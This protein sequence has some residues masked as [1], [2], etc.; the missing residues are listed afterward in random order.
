MMWRCVADFSIFALRFL[1]LTLQST[2]VYFTN[3]KYTISFMKKI[4]LLA[5]IVASMAFATQAETIL[6]ESFNYAVGALYG[7]GKWVKYGAKTSAPIQVTDTALTFADYQNAAAGK[8]VA[9][10]KEQGESLQALFRDKGTSAVDGA[11]YYSALINLTS[12]PSGSRTTAF[13]ALTGANDDDL[14]KY[15]DGVAGSE[16][17]G[18]FAQASGD[19]FK[20]GVSRSVLVSG[21]TKSNVCWSEKELA[22]GTT[23][24]VVVKYVAT[25]GDANGAISLWIDPAKSETEPTADVAASETVSGT[26]ADVRGIELRQGSSMMAK[27]PGVV[28][29]QVRVATT[30]AEVFSPKG[31]EVVLTPEITVSDLTLDFGKVYQGLTYTKTVNIKAKNL[32]GDITVSGLQS[33]L[34]TAS[35]TTIA[36]ADAESADGYNL[37]LTLNVA[38]CGKTSDAVTFSAKDAQ[39]RTQVVNWRP[40]ETVA[41]NSL[42]ELYDENNINMTTIYVFKG[43][44]T[45]TAIDKNFYTFYAQ[46]A[47][48]AVEIR[49]ASGCGYDEVDL[50][51]VKQGDNITNL[52]CNVIFSD[53]GGIDLVPMAPDAWQVTS[54]GNE[55][56]PQVMT[57]EQIHAAE[58][59]DAMFKLITVKNVKF[60]E[61]YGSYPDPDYYGKFNTPFHLVNDGTRN[62]EIWYFRGTDIYNSSTK[63]YFNSVWSVTGICYFLTPVAAV[64]PR[65]LTDFVKT[66]ES[67]VETVK[68]GDA[69]T[70]VAYYDLCGRKVSNPASGFYIVKYS[71][72]TTSKINVKK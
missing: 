8:A 42:K 54:T 23:Y 70:I 37:E 2:I 53:D 49:S 35:A 44:A 28:I 50:T 13:L 59:C 34:L 43:E 22:L 52:V 17:A 63:G 1:F 51:K 58:A 55:V 61:K 30:W 21:N 64:A 38:N 26:L 68:T 12:Q 48:S 62:G 41:V 25:A 57:F 33:K 40:I 5:S 47:A 46:D 20:L 67:G 45:V 3:N 7:N 4:L 19:G 66:G 56:T 15:G 36:K 9:L 24:L 6:N 69:A 11:I 72:G 27:V 39:S 18:L 10:T 71:D 29:D 16:G 14:T 65:A 60:D 32:T 31:G